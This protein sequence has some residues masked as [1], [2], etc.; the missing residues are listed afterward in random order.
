MSLTNVYAL[1][2]A[3][4]IDMELMRKCP[5]STPEDHMSLIK[6]RYTGKLNL[7]N[8]Y[9]DGPDGTITL[10]DIEEYNKIQEEPKEI[11]IPT[12][13]VEIHKP[14]SE[15][16]VV[17]DKSILAN[18]RDRA[19]LLDYLKK[20]A[21]ERIIK[22]KDTQGNIL[23][24]Q[25]EAVIA[26]YMKTTADI[27]DK[28]DKMKISLREE[29]KTKKII[30]ERVDMILIPI[31]RV[32]KEHIKD[33]MLLKKIFKELKNTFSLWKIKQQ[34]GDTDEKIETD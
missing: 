18:Y 32:L 13:K 14:G 3:I 15:N 6:M 22:I 5:N 26:M 2:T 8:I 9:E 31:V 28:E 34:V 19:Q 4:K 25:L 16:L 20:Q 17:D 30:K 12:G 29:G 33:K 7:L 24:P 11:M 27:V 10:K 1:P 21:V 23:I